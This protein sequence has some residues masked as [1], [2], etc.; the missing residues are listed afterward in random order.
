MRRRFFPFLVILLLAIPL[1]FLV[2]TL[3]QALF[4]SL[5]LTL[6]RWWSLVAGFP[7]YVCWALFLSVAFVLAAASLIRVPKG[8]R[9]TPSPAPDHPGPVE[10]LARQMRLL[11]QGEYFQWRIANHLSE[12]ALRILTYSGD[13]PLDE[14][15]TAL[16]EGRWDG[17]PEIR[18]YFQAGLNPLPVGHTPP[19]PWPIRWLRRPSPPSPFC[20][21][22][23]SVVRFLEEQMKMEDEDAGI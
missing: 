17:P 1:F 9:R 20:L 22:P 11:G 18:Y 14:A 19:P 6:Q 2:H 8:E 12:L 21:D 15:R 4:P 3:V 5:F 23:E 10:A 16:R 13:L 7:Q